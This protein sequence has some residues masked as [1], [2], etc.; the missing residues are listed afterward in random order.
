MTEHDPRCGCP[1][2]QLRPNRADRRRMARMRR[3]A[4]NVSLHIPGCV[5]GVRASSPPDRTAV[6]AASRKGAA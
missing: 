3:E 4:P 6:H 2:V 1:L 5:I